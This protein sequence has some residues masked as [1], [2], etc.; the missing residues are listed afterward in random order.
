MS[1]S[2]PIALLC[3]VA[4]VSR[5]GY[6]K[7]LK[8]QKKLTAKQRED[9]EFKKQIIEAHSKYKGIFGYPRMTVWLRKQTGKRINHKRVY[10][11]MKELGVQ[12]HIRK[13]RVYYGKKE[14]YV[15]SHNHLNREFTASRPNEKWVTDITYLIFKGKRLY[16][17]VILD[18]YNNEVIAYKISERNDVKLV[19]D[20][21]KKAIKKRDVNGLLLH[22]DQGYQYIS[23]K[24]HQ[25]LQRYNIKASMSRK[26]NCLDNACIE[27]FFSHLKS[28]C[29]YQ[30]EF[31]H[32]WEVKRAIHEYIQFYNEERF[33]KK[34]N[35]LSP[36]EYRRKVA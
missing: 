18:L 25:L 6:Y 35:N 4:G 10:R 34:L 17:S 19:L 1:S 28:E 23:R 9:Q 36:V 15:V 8:T 11:L 33:Q 2:Y 16:L 13:K 12:A 3:E 32:S 22:S 26:G 5:S 29:F 21:V 31:Q 20:T 7:W 14:V 30:Y 27:S 24:Y